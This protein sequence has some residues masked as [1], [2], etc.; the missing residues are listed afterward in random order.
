MRVS[1]LTN[2]MSKYRSGAVRDL[3]SKVGRGE[4][5]VFFYAAM[6]ALVLLMI[7]SLGCGPPSSSGPGGTAAG[8]APELTQEVVNE[9]IND[10]YVRNVPE[11]NGSGEPIGW[12]FDEDE[13]KEVSVVEKQ[14]EQGKATLI[15]DIKTTSSPRANNKRY[16]A[17]QVRTEWRLETGWVLRRWEVVE[18][19]NISMKYRNL[20]K[21]PAQ[22]SNR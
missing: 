7:A 1:D 4:N 12:S 13:P 18:I 19:E 16:L 17:G 9:R 10:A 5:V 21:D 15:L 20:P 14:I 8:D 11:E 22:N 3:R 2:E 6:P